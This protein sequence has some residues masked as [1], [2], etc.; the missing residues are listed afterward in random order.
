MT[1]TGSGNKLA[2]VAASM[3]PNGAAK[4]YRTGIAGLEELVVSECVDPDNLRVLL[5][6]LGDEDCVHSWRNF[7]PDG[8]LEGLLEW[9]NKL[10]PTKIFFFHLDRG[11]ETRMIAASAVAE[12]LTRDFPHPGFC[13][14]GRC[15]IMP[16]FRGMGFYRQ[17]LRYRLEH[18][19]SQFGNE[20]NGV[21]IGS[22]NER[23]SRVITNHGLTGWPRFIHLGEEELKVAGQIRTVGAYLMFL[24][25]YIHRLKNMLA[26]DDAPS[27]VV[28]LRDALSRIESD[29]TRNLGT[30]VKENFEKA[31]EHGWFEN[32]GSHEI[33]QLL[34]FCGS[35]PLVGFK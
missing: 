2:E 5:G 24:P 8:T 10:R 13:V 14:L 15:Y 22:V 29:D 27:C 35:I 7:G 11:G 4:L 6:C 34:R 16:Q 28:K 9:E 12:K 18:C 26:G 33:K 3:S 19:R 30:L 20:L 25:E 21:H 32:R 31:I 17:I 1:I 23:I